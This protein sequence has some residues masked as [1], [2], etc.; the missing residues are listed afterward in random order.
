MNLDKGKANTG[1]QTVTWTETG[2][3]TFVYSERINQDKQ[4]DSFRTRANSF[5]DEFYS[6]EASEDTLNTAFT[7]FMNS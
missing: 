4:K 1:F 2:K 3:T 6:K 7:T 5:K